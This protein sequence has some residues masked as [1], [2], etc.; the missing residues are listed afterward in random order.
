MD[1]KKILIVLDG[2]SDLSISKFDGKTP[3]DVAHTPHLDSLVKKGMMGF[4]H[5]INDRIVPGSDNSLISIFGNDFRICRR[6]IFEAVGAGFK[7]KRG[8]LAL[9]ANFG[10]IDNLKNKKV[11][12]RRAGR[13]LTNK[14][15]K[16]LA[17]SLNKNVKLPCKFEFRA[18][19]QHRGALVLRGG[20]SDNISSID[21]ELGGKKEKRFHYSE[22][23]D[24]DENSEY[25]A[26][27][28]NDFV[29]QA[30]KVLNNH[31]VNLKRKEKGL[32]PANFV[33]L[34]GGG[35]EKPKIKQYRRWMSINS[36]PLE[37]GIAKLSGMTNF[38]FP[39]PELRDIDVY[40]N[41]YKGLKK[42]I[43]FA[44]QSIQKNHSDFTGCYIQFKET[45]VPG[46][47]NKP[48]DKKKM[49]EIIDKKFFGF[50]VKFIEKN[51]LRVVVTCD[52][53]TPCEMKAHSAHPV[54]VLVYPGKDLTHR[55]NEIESRMGG[56][57]EFYG[58]DFMRV[59]GLDK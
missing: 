2:A 13:T 43:D 36:M 45:D 32:F 11:I 55:F 49:I 52:H 59:T 57:G 16:E 26:K 37:I 30:F 21:S 44:I 38:S 42:S 41:L 53:S 34:R 56:L 47:D 27:V 12:D 35:I 9:R 24:N 39:Y 22:S 28:L 51:P 8:D 5:P 40:E 23:L 4:M 50:L 46:H 7:L 18:T 15:A 54:P 19:I 17:D 3:F 10:T 1:M 33:F 31:P 20:F 6:G 58:R 14:E 29:A 48:Y 25:S